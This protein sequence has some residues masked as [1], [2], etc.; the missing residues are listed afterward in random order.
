VSARRHGRAG[1]GPADRGGEGG[2]SDEGAEHGAR[3]G[4]VVSHFGVEVEVA[5]ADGERGRVAIRRRSH[6]VVGDR[7]RL[8][9]GGL[10]ALPAEGVLRRRDRRGRVR[11]VAANLDAMGIVLAPE[12]ETPDAFVDRAIVGARAA[13]VAPFFVVNK[14]DLPRAGALAER[15]RALW[16]GVEPV[17]VISAETGAGLGA[18]GEYLAG[19]RRAVFVG[20]S[21]VGKSSLANALVGD[22]ELAVGATNPASGLGRHVTTN[23]T[24]HRLAGG[25]ELIDTPGFRDFGP[26]AVSAGALAAW[27]PGFE[28]PLAEGCRYRDCR[29]RS[30]PGCAVL[31]AVAVGR[32]P[33]ERHAAYLALQDELEAAERAARGY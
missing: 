9:A 5:W 18:I 27:F 4:T 19:G 28:A 8:Q 3:A 21:G 1:A 26:V 2:G 22:A 10:E 30:E 17:L 29:H 24:L 16:P 15:M 31:E 12:P 14:A 33:A 32:V 13:G 25:G 20:V 6:F 11:T 7:V 23:A